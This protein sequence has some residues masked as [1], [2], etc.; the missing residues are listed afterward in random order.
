MKISPKGNI[1]WRMK[2]NQT[3]DELEENIC[4]EMEIMMK[5]NENNKSEMGCEEYN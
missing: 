5:Q 1:S 2:Q 4:Y 3:Q